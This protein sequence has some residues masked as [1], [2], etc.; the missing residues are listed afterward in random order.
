M[1]LLIFILICFPI[2]FIIWGFKSNSAK[3]DRSKISNSR[4]GVR[5]KKSKYQRDLFAADLTNSTIFTNT[6]SVKPRSTSVEPRSTSVEPRSTSVEPR[7]ISVEPRSISVEPRSISVEPRSISALP[8]KRISIVDGEHRVF[9]NVHINGQQYSFG[10]PKPECKDQRVWVGLNEKEVERISKSQAENRLKGKDLGY[11]IKKLLRD[12]NH[13]SNK[14]LDKRSSKV[15]S[16]N[17]VKSREVHTKGYCKKCDKKLIG[18]TSKPL[19]HECWSKSNSRRGKY[20]HCNRCGK[21]L[22]GDISKPLCH[23]CWSDS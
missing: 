20:G 4:S 19:C 14:L 1:E 7:S 11:A 9:Q 15:N 3:V 17:K 10:F 12:S 23:A 21:K 16:R 5:L 18:D 8:E 6:T 2:L 13:S 22:Q